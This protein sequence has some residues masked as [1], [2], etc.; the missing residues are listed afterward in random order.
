MPPAHQTETLED[1]LTQVKEGKL[2]AYTI[3]KENKL[4][5]VPLFN[6]INQIDKFEKR[7]QHLKREEQQRA[8]NKLKNIDLSL[9]NDELLS[10]LTF[11]NNNLKDRRYKEPMLH[12]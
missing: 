12:I 4:D 6:K 2:D 10:V 11:I 1:V 9:F 3:I 5:I 7:L 8:K